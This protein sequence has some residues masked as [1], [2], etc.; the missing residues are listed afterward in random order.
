MCKDCGCQ[1][2][3]EKKY[4]KHNHEHHHDHNHLHSHDHG[5]SHDHPHDNDHNHNHS[6]EHDHSLLHARTVILE[7]NVLAK[8]EEIAAKNKVWFKDRGI[9]AVNIISSPGSGK[10]TLLEK[11]LDAFKGKIHCSVIVGDQS[12][13]NDAKRLQGRCDSVY[14]I[15]THASCHLN[16]EQISEVL[17]KVVNDKTELLFIE[18]VGNLICPAAFELG[19]DFKVVLL[20][21]TEGEDKPVKYPVIF[22]DSPVAIITKTDLIPYLDWDIKKCRKHIREINPGMFIFELS[23]KTGE[24]MNS[25]LDY[26][27]KLVE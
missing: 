6:H 3:N 8:N 9:I 25:W 16:A 2:G 1:E 11:T 7:R 26:L 12:T 17:P 20:S 10:T 22:S 13:D 14:Q 23:A 18:N 24:G 21:S 19:E 5:H 15:E 27:T 4:F